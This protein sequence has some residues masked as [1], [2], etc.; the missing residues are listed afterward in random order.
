M[1]ELIDGEIKEL[2]SKI[3]KFD[4]HLKDFKGNQIVCMDLIHQKQ[5]AKHKIDCYKEIKENLKIIELIKKYGGIT[6]EMSYIKLENSNKKLDVV[7]D[8]WFS[9]I[10][11][12]NNLNADNDEIKDYYTIKK[13]CKKHKVG[14]S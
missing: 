7:N 2:Q 8:Q 10:I 3:R 14:E 4:K 12:S 11:E 1:N 5:I 9:C 6:Y 13:W